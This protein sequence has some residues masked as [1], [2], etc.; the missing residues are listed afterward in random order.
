MLLFSL[1]HASFIHLF[2][3]VILVVGRWEQ[4]FNIKS[5]YLL[6]TSTL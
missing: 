4:K 3:C 2:F 5:A 1:Q 6:R